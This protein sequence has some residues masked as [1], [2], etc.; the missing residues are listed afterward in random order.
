VVNAV[1]QRAAE[2]G[3]W[4]KTAWGAALFAVFLAIVLWFNVV[5]FYHRHFF[6]HGI[7]VLVD[8]LARIGFLLVLSWLIYA[9]GAAVAQVLLPDAHC[10]GLTS[11]ERSV[12]AFGIGIGLWHVLLLILGV[13]G[14]YYR[15]IMVGI[16]AIVLL[17]SARLFGIVASAACR[18]LATRAAGLRRGAGIPEALCL[19]L[20]VVCV[21]WL[22]LV[23]GLY[24]GGGGDY[25][26]HY[27]YYYLDVLKNHDLAPNHVWYHYFYSKGYGLFFLGML[28][29][30]P[31]APA[32]VTFCCVIFAAV[33][34]AVLAQ[35][36]APRSL[37]P[38]CVAALY[39]LFNVIGD[40]RARGNGGGHFQK[41]HEQVS[42]LIVLIAVALCMA[43]GSAAQRAWLTMAASSAVAVAIIAQPMGVIIGFY[44]M[45]VALW[46][47]L[48]RQWG[49]MRLFGLA[50][51]VVAGTVAAIF[52]L[53]YW[54]TGLAH[55][56]ALELML[57]FADMTRLDRWGVLPQLVI[58]SWIRGNYLIE[59]APWSWAFTTMPRHFMRLDQLWLFLA[60]PAALLGL[61]AVRAALSR[62]RGTH[63]KPAQ[64]Q[65]ADANVFAM[66]GCLV[67]L[68]AAIAAIGVV[69]GRPQ[70]V[71]FERASTFSS[72]CCCCS[73][74]HYAAGRWNAR[75]PGGNGDFWLGWCLCSCS[76]GAC[77]FG[78]RTSIGHAG[79]PKQA[80]TGCVFS[81]VATTLPKPIHIR[82]PDYP[83]AA[84]IRA[85][86]PPGGK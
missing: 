56:Q 51:I 38:A 7:V 75:P 68:I 55:D 16:A 1:E 69:A 76:A 86:L 21:I 24:P 60:G 32:L 80:K 82:M 8:N 34:M 29:T 44:F 12:L 48:R 25:Y 35:R 70:P 5:D 45:L 37:W 33:A 85:R 20:V 79:P 36:I 39:L 72:R 30:D 28:L 15:S 13:A 11:A 81:W 84:L 54:A 40:A 71:S 22:L 57:R 74:W 67:S 64:A 52:A 26:T 43:R 19:L 42:A 73:R 63:L 66:I 62:L 78:R 23:R 83:S 4:A 27:F 61:V 65:S 47:M 31:E 58:V 49:E 46:A 9:P 2:I 18:T 17:A 53:G 10:A 6:D 41:D 50:G 77:C 59:A 3:V 14:L